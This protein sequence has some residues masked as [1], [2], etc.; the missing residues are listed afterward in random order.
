[1]INGLLRKFFTK[2]TSREIAKKRLKLALIY[3]KTEVSEDLLG[4]LQ[5]DIVKVISR[6]FEIDNKS[7]KLD[8]QRSDDLSALVF[9]TP[10]LKAK[11]RAQPALN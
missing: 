6:Y 2:N 1:M 9:N 10:I 5:R 4:E 11:H 3:D 7:L 8:I